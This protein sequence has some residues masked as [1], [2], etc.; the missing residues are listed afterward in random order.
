MVMR[1]TRASPSCVGHGREVSARLGHHGEEVDLSAPAQGLEGV[2]QAQARTAVQR[3]R[4]LRGHHQG[5]HRERPL[6]ASEPGNRRAPP[7]DAVLVGRLGV[8]PTRTAGAL[9]S[10]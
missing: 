1:F 8:S 3:P 9:P 4:V 10:A 2:G 7:R 6:M 5:P